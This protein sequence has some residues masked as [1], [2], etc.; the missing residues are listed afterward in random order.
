MNHLI[1]WKRYLILDKTTQPQAY[2]TQQRKKDLDR[3]ERSSSFI[4]VLDLDGSLIVSV[5]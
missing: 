4:A 5:W 1:N 2:K 3:G